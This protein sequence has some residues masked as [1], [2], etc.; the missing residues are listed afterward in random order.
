MANKHLFFLK[1][2]VSQFSKFRLIVDSEL[3]P[4]LYFLFQ[5]KMNFIINNFE[6]LN[7]CGIFI[8]SKT[9]G[10]LEYY[11]KSYDRITTKLEKRLARVNRLFHKVTTTDDPIIRKVSVKCVFL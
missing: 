11:D 10:E 5:Q 3:Q 4:T 7:W 2:S 6:Y 1:K 9:C 8:C